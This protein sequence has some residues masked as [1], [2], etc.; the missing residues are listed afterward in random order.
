MSKLL[1]KKDFLHLIQDNMDS[2]FALDAVF[3]VICI[4]PCAFGNSRWS[5][6][7]TMGILSSSIGKSI[8][9]EKDKY[10][11]FNNKFYI[12]TG[13]QNKGVINDF[14]KSLASKVAMR[15]GDEIYINAG[16]IQ[17]P[18]DAMNLPGI[19]NCLASKMEKVVLRSYD[20]E[21]GIIS[22]KDPNYVLGVELT[23]FLQNINSYSEILY[24]HSLLVA[25]VSFELSKK[26]NFASQASKKV[27]IAALLHDLGYLMIDKKIFL[28]DNN[29]K[30]KNSKTIQLH[31]LLAT[32]KILK[33]KYIF[34]DIFSLIEQHHEF[35]DGGGY[36]FGLVRTELSFESQILSLADTYA[37]IQE[38]SLISLEA[39]IDFF[40]ARA[41]FRWNSELIEAFVDILKDDKAREVLHDLSSAS[42]KNLFDFK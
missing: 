4:E 16:F 21:T 40:E 13:V 29:L 26:F 15:F 2:L 38:Q 11:F 23:N 27:F 14:I 1:A 35:L 7:E 42:L 22:E 33:D 12:F 37:T 32:R 36:P 24:K 9:K 5:P 8:V 10:S 41:G 3:S 30:M 28:G 17:Y 39:I 19:F 34:N 6:H 25:K 31:P 20:F 18:Y